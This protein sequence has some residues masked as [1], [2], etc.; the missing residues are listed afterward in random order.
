M[1]FRDVHCITYT[2]HYNAMYWHCI[3]L[4]ASVHFICLNIYHVSWWF[5]I[6]TMSKD[7]LG[8]KSVLVLLTKTPVNKVHI[9][10]VVVSRKLLSTNTEV[11]WLNYRVPVI[12]SPSVCFNAKATNLLIAKYFR[13]VQS[14]TFVSYES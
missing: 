2:W 14:E 3:V 1:D 13:S 5:L 9:L 6:L 7:L 11:S 12:P 4:C 8:F 10:T